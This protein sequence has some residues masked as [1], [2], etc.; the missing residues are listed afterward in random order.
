MCA[1]RVVFKGTGTIGL[2][3]RFKSQG[4]AVTFGTILKHA[5]VEVLPEAQRHLKR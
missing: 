2:T 5:G 1:T 3:A 4:G